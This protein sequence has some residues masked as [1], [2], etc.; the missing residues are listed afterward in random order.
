MKSSS[1]QIMTEDTFKLHISREFLLASV[2]RQIFCRYCNTVLDVRS[3]VLADGTDEEPSLGMAL[4]C[5]K[6]WIIA[7]PA[8]DNAYGEGR[9]TIYDGS[10]LYGRK[11][12]RKAS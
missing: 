11:P 10:K 3:A 8:L 5:G 7:K 4:M 2:Q 6:C 1:P 12:R 9:F